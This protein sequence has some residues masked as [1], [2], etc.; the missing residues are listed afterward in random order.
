MSVLRRAASIPTGLAR[1]LARQP[2][3]DPALKRQPP[4]NARA[5]SA[6]RFA[7]LFAVLLHATTAELPELL[8]TALAPFLPE[9]TTNPEPDVLCK[10]LRAFS[11][12]QYDPTRTTD[13]ASAHSAYAN[14]LL[15]LA[16]TRALAEQNCATDEDASPHI[17]TPPADEPAPEVPAVESLGLHPVP[18]DEAARR[19]AGV[20]GPKD[21]AE[22]RKPEM[23]DREQEGRAEAEAALRGLRIQTARR[24]SSPT[25]PTR[26]RSTRRSRGGA[27]QGPTG[28]ADA[29][30]ASG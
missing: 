28:T 11:E 21:A 5:R 9:A 20:F 24:S 6:A 19:A 26:R 25:S 27:R 12:W 17:S 2:E 13:P 22:R 18:D 29:R 16:A 3:I 23:V 1:R 8:A 10:A 4:Q 7:V 30:P 15:G 14:R